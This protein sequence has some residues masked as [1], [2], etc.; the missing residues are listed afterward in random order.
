MGHGE[1][2]FGASSTVRV[3]KSVGTPSLKAVNPADFLEGE[4]I[5]AFLGIR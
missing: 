1:R 2:R 4:R 3:D 5:A